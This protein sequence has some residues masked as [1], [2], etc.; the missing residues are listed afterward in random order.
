MVTVARCNNLDE[1]QLLKTRLAGSGI[2]AF[3]PDEFMAQNEWPALSAVG[4]IR[5]QVP[6]DQAEAARRVIA[7]Q[8]GTS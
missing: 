7:D 8:G 5:V 3:I 2:T 6:P 4:G 1:A